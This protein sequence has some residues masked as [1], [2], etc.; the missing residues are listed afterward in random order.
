MPGAVHNQLTDVTCPKIGRNVGVWKGWTNPTPPWRRG[1]NPDYLGIF[2]KRH[3]C[4]WPDDQGGAVEVWPG[5]A[6]VLDAKASE[7]DAVADLEKPWRRVGQQVANLFGYVAPIGVLDRNR[8]PEPFGLWEVDDAGE[9]AMVKAPMRMNRHASWRLKLMLAKLAGDP[10]SPAA[11]ASV[12]QPRARLGSSRPSYRLTARELEEVRRHADGQPTPT[13]ILARIAGVKKRDLIHDARL[14]I[15]G[16]VY[17][18]RE[19]ELVR[20]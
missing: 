3:E 8:V 9:F 5:D 11:A 18:E 7:S 17:H 6:L 19:D 10:S 14:G 13:I 15:E 16:L 1:E 20:G 4:I 2:D 12:S